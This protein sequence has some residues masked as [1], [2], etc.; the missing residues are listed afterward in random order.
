MR[1]T[2]TSG[3]SRP[4]LKQGDRK[5][6]RG[7]E[8]I[9]VFRMSQGCVV[10]SSGRYCYDWVPVSEAKAYGAAYCWTDEEKAKYDNE[11]PL[12]Y[13]QGRGAA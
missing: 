12:G 4:K 2:I 13:M 10:V 11:Y 5:I 1:I 9:R 6:I 7:I 3:P 8:H